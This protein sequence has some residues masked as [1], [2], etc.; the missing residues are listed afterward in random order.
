MASSTPF[1]PADS[2]NEVEMTFRQPDVPN[3]GATYDPSA[4]PD[5]DDLRVELNSRRYDEKWVNQIRSAANKKSFPLQLMFEPYDADK[6][7]LMT[8]GDLAASRS[9]ET[10]I[11]YLYPKRVKHILLGHHGLAKGYKLSNEIQVC[12]KRDLAG[13]LDPRF[14]ITSGRNRT[15]AIILLL[16]HFGI[17][18]DKQKV[19]VSSKV[20]SSKSEFKQLIM[21]ANDC[22]KMKGAETRNHKLG[23]RGVE[24]H[25][26]DRFYSTVRLARKNECP[27]A[28]AAACRFTAIN[29]PQAFQDK[30]Y[31]Y[32]ASGYGQAM[33]TSKENSAALMELIKGEGRTDELKNL[34]EKISEQFLQLIAAGLEHFP[35]KYENISSPRQVAQAICRMLELDIPTYG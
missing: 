14:E 30:L 23:A 20:V 35:D 10:G 15:T 18:W 26:E 34:A 5:F 27:A 33:R 31:T 13:E 11:Q 25:D 16:Q 19:Y 24:T 28:F 3:P 9:H 4:N 21:D 32:T 29:K 6:A 22:R 17:K 7:H 12:Y 8:L 2:T 1:Q